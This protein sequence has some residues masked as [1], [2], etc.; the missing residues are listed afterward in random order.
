L[1]GWTVLCKV[2]SAYQQS[3]SSDHLAIPSWPNSPTTTPRESGSV[4]RTRPWLHTCNISRC[5]G[6]FP[7]NPNATKQYQGRYASIWAPGSVTHSFCGRYF[8]AA[9]FLS[10]VLLSSDR[11]AC[12][13]KSR[14]GPETPTSSA[15]DA[16]HTPTIFISLWCTLRVRDDPDS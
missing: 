8:D 11:C 7:G 12:W 10:K 15:G 16:P 6:V 5:P 13:T 3:T 14:Q 4:A 1:L 2:V 9:S